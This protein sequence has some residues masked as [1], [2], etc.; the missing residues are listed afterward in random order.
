MLYTNVQC[1]VCASCAFVCACVCVCRS[2][3][4]SERI[5]ILYDRPPNLKCVET[6][7]KNYTQ[8]PKDIDR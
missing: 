1:I 5:S 4:D 3:L 6:R 2:D 7:S 8:L